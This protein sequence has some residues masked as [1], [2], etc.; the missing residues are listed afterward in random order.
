APPPAV[1]TPPLQGSSSLRSDSSL[2]SGELSEVPN[3]C[4]TGF[5]HLLWE[6]GQEVSN[7]LPLA[8][9]QA[10]KGNL[11]AQAFVP[12]VSPIFQSAGAGREPFRKTCARQTKV[13]YP[14]YL[15]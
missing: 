15:G 5:Y 3:M 13:R 10:G 8:E 14:H 11:V 4:A 7:Y 12:A 2:M 9:R 6:N 1:E